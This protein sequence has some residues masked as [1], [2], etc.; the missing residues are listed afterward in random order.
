MYNY[1]NLFQS[2]VSRGKAIKRTEGGKGERKG[3]RNTSSGYLREREY[4]ESTE[5][6]KRKKT[7]YPAYCII[8]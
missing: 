7:F 1:T 8:T 2:L 5:S 6:K 3:E 4:D